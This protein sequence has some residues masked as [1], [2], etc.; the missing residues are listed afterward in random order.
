LEPGGAPT[1]AREEVIRALWRLGELER[2]GKDSRR[3]RAFLSGGW[4][5]LRFGAHPRGLVWLR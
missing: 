1:S 5:L 3:G 2:K 4:R